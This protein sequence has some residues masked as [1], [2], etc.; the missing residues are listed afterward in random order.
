MRLLTLSMCI[1]AAATVAGAVSG[2]RPKLPGGF[3]VLPCVETPAEGG[4][5]VDTKYRPSC[6]DRFDTKV[7]FTKLNRRT[8]VF[9]SRGKG[10]N[11]ST[12]TCAVFEGVFRFDR[13]MRAK[14][15]G[16]KGM[17]PPKSEKIVKDKEYE[18]TADFQACVATINGEDVGYYMPHGDFKT[19]SDLLL[20]ALANNGQKPAKDACAKSMR[21]YGFSIQDENG[22]TKAELV[23]A[24]RTKDGAQ[25]F[26]DTARKMFLPLEKVAADAKKKGK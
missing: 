19:K 26:Y 3:E 20:F 2:D 6:N 22:K 18:I 4:Q 13:N 9:S 1:L 10:P 25:G 15:E 11:D 23:P 7:S 24:K 8:A 14:T 17:A 16:A 5:Y 21:M 12:M